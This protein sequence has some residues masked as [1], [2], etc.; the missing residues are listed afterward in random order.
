LHGLLGEEYWLAWRKTETSYWRWV[1]S[2][3]LVLPSV[4][5]KLSF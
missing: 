4:L 1:Q 2:A 3:F 5:Q